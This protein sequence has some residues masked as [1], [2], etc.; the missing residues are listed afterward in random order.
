MDCNQSDQV[1]RYI[2]RIEKTEEFMDSVLQ[3]A[4]LAEE[5][6]MHNLVLYRCLWKGVQVK[7]NVAV[8]IYEDYFSSED[9]AT[10]AEEFSVDT[11]ISY[12]DPAHARGSDRRPVR[13]N[14]NVRRIC[15]NM[16]CKYVCCELQNKYLLCTFI[17]A[18]LSTITMS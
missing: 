10:R 7:Q 18:I 14:M 12:P 17:V 11:I 16:R 1:D 5:K 6:V 3:F 2:K 4:V 13:R 15:A 8:E 9:A